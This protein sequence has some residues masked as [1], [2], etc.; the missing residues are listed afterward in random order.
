MLKLIQRSKAFF[1]EYIKCLKLS[2]DKLL[3]SINR[4]LKHK[5]KN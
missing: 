5:I 1:P 3:Y 4:N 2:I